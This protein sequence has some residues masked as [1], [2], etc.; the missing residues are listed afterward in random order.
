[1]ARGYGSG[2]CFGQEWLI[3]HIGL[4]IEYDDFDAAVSAARLILPLRGAFELVS[5]LP[6]EAKGGVH[7]DV[8]T[9]DDKNA[10][11]FLHRLRH[12]SM[13]HRLLSVC[14]QAQRNCATGGSFVSAS[15]RWSLAYEFSQ[16]SG[17]RESH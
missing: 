10:S 4:G 14:P 9:A 5:E 17:V 7:A 13:T 1:M 6:L 15:L 8:A 16:F 11:G 12:S 3:R 2:R